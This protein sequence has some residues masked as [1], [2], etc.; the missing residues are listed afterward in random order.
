[1]GSMGINAQ[2]EV[3]GKRTKLHIEAMRIVAAFFVIFNH[4]GL[5]GFLLFETYESNTP[6]F[7]AYLF[8]SIFCKFSVPLFFM[9]SGA[10]LLN[11]RESVGQV[12][13]YRIAKIALVLVLFN[14]ISYAQRIYLGE[15]SFDITRFLTGMYTGDW[16]GAYWYLYS[17]IGFLIGLPILRLFLANINGRHICYI[18]AIVLFFDGLLPMMEYALFRGGGHVKRKFKCWMDNDEHI[19]LSTDRLLS[20]KSSGDVWNKEKTVFFMDN[21]CAVHNCVLLYDIL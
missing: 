14:I 3:T 19:L 9:I 17:F 18:M 13:K 15:E 1:M 6:F 20:G 8:V 4:T 7:W 11:K 16:N 5:N 10:L 12:W 2:R 21:K